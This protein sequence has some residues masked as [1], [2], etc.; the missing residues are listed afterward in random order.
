MCRRAPTYYFG[1]FF[2]E[3]CTKMKEIR[4][5]MRGRGTRV[6][7]DPFNPPEFCDIKKQFFNYLPL[8]F[9]FLGK[10]VLCIY[11]F[12]LKIKLW[13]S[14]PP[15]DKTYF[16]K[17]VLLRERK[18]HTARRVLSTPSVVLPVNPLPVLTWIGVG[19]VPDQGTPLAG[20]PPAGP[21][22]QVPPPRLDLAGY[23]PAGYPPTRYRPSWTWQDNPRPLPPPVS[24][25]WHSGKCC[26]ALWDMGTPPPVDR[27]IDGWMEGQTRVKTLPSVVLRT[28]AVIILTSILQGFYCKVRTLCNYVMDN[29]TVNPGYRN[30][31]VPG[32]KSIETISM[33]KRDRKE[34]RSI[35]KDGGRVG[36]LDEHTL[37]YY[38]RISH[39]FQEDFESD[40][41][42]GM[43]G[44][45][46]L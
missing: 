5:P 25:P 4:P 8:Q 21:P 33:K 34:N 9:P 22:S 38:R 27:Q 41:D 32:T 29:R 12:V 13:N 43:N 2:P 3:N 31:V 14:V 42:K 1:N 18:R 15:L 11:L 16:N 28:R 6:P 10:F 20:Y 26:K 17:K 46:T 35:E 36:R 30:D 24:A 23:P 45:Q 40:E 19:G 7:K 39:S 37:G 44:F